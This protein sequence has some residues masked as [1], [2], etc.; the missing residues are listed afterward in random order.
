MRN[1]NRIAED[2]AHGVAVKLV[3]QCGEAAMGRIYRE[4]GREGLRRVV[5]NKLEPLGVETSE[6]EAVVFEV[7][8]LVD[9]YRLMPAPSAAPERGY[10]IYRTTE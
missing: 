8:E 10:S 7:A 4:Q 9:G 3:A 2:Y 5:A 1:K 6:V